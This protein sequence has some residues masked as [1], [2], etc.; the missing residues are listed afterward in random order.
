MYFQNSRNAGWVSFSSLKLY[1]VNSLLAFHN[2]HINFKPVRT[3]TNNPFLF[4]TDERWIPLFS[5]KTLANCIFLI[6]HY[7]GFFKAN[8]EYRFP[9]YNH[10]HTHT[11]RP[12]YE[13]NE[14]TSLFTI[15]FF[16]NISGFKTDIPW[17]T[18]SSCNRNSSIPC[19]SNTKFWKKTNGK[20]R[21]MT[22]VIILPL[23][24]NMGGAHPSHPLCS[25]CHSS[26]KIMGP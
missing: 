10:T 25:L 22:G 21:K 17:K 1:N 15:C 2:I 5:W 7:H 20:K 12:V 24:R 9:L 19:L 11:P 18:C 16:W 4:P 8:G 23:S 3:T 26:K 14:Q 13:Q 6:N